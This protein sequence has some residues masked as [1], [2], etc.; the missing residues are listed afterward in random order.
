MLT[1]RWGLSRSGPLKLVVCVRLKALRPDERVYSTV[2]NTLYF[3]SASD[4]QDGL[5]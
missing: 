3:P 4:G 5:N 1:I 2:E